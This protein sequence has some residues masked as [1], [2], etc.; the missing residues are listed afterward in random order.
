MSHFGYRDNFDGVMKEG[1]NILEDKATIH[2]ASNIPYVCKYVQH[3][4][5]TTEEQEFWN[6]TV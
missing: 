1:G 4:C 5:T 6:N 2:V 3:M